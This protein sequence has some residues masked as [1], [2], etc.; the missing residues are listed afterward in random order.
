MRTLLE[1]VRSRPRGRIA[2]MFWLRDC[3]KR[4]KDLPLRD[5][6]KVCKQE[7]KEVGEG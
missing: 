2:T 1:Y 4:H 3:Y 6:V 7:L 5:R